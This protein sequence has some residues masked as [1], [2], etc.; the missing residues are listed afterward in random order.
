MTV[1]NRAARVI[2]PTETGSCNRVTN[3]R[4]AADG[5][6]GINRRNRQSGEIR[7]NPGGAYGLGIVCA[8]TRTRLSSA[9][10]KWAFLQNRQIDG[11]VGYANPR[12]DCQSALHCLNIFRALCLAGLSTFCCQITRAR[13]PFESP[14]RRFERH[15]TARRKRRLSDG[16]RRC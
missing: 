7:V 12:A 2:Y 16:H 5:G 8:I 15:Y 10:L 1:L 9:C 11:A 13:R 6:C 4:D 3:A 14:C